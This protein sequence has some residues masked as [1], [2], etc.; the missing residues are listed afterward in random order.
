MTA[1]HS[2]NLS[3]C[4]FIH[5]H[6]GLCFLHL[7]YPIILT[8]V[9]RCLGFSL[10]SFFA[11]LNCPSVGVLYFRHDGPCRAPYSSSPAL[12]VS[13]SKKGANIP[14]ISVSPQIY[15]LKSP[16]STKLTTHLATHRS[17]PGA[18]TL[19]SFSYLVV[20]HS[21]INLKA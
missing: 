2:L 6:D 18:I 7:N 9:S 13:L 12:V 21:C 20:S 19:I 15:H 10:P 5:S 1:R 4:S 3:R 14:K 11:L 17:L 8:Q 16:E